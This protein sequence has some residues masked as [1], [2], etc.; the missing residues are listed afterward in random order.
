M[1][2]FWQH[3]GAALGDSFWVGSWVSVYSIFWALLGTES[4]VVGPRP[5]WRGML[6]LVTRDF[7][8]AVDLRPQWQRPPYVVTMRF[9][10]LVGLRPQWRELP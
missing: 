8:M 7:A 3:M 4:M 10:T 1:T 9:A 6:W 5:Q 2:K